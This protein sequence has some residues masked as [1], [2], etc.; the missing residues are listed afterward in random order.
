MHLPLL[1]G[2]DGSFVSNGGVAFNPLRRTAGS[3]ADPFF[4]RVCVLKIVFAKKAIKNTRFLVAA[5]LDG[6]EQSHPFPAALFKLT[7]ATAHKHKM[8]CDSHIYRLTKANPKRSFSGA[9]ST[10]MQTD[11]HIM[12]FRLHVSG[13]T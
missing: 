11:T 10:G 12:Y 8:L 2:K 6:L 5:W 7:A 3:S 9:P 4:M 13:V 1:S